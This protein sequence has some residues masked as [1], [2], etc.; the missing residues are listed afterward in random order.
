MA[1]TVGSAE[2]AQRRA[3][4]ELYVAHERGLYNVAYRY[5]WSADEARDVV[6]DAFVRLWRKRDT[7]DW[8][9]AAGLAY[10]IVLGL[11]RNRR[12]AF[13]IRRALGLGREVLAATAPDAALAAAELDAAVR[14]CIDELPDRLRSVLVM[15]QYSGL[16]H[17]QIAVALDIAVGTVGS[18]RNEAIARV[19]A[20]LQELGHA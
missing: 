8:E 5:V 6:H 4:E 3:L 11:A 7:V 20:R 17:A 13:S 9:R 18:R 14:R 19:R 12:R 10:T 1:P 15:C 16:D 2:P